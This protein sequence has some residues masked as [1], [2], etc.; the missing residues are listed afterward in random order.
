LIKDGQLFIFR[1]GKTYNAT[2]TEVK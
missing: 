1:N 2:G